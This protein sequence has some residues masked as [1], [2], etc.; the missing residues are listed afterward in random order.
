[1]NID[2]FVVD[3]KE[4]TISWSL[5]GTPVSVNCPNLE[6]ARLF[7][8]SDIVLAISGENGLC[9]TL[10]GFSVEGM[11]KF[12]VAAPEGFL[13]SYLIEHVT[14][15]IA[16]VCAGE[17]YIEGWY[18]WHFAVDPSSGKLSRHCPAY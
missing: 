15:G 8:K 14:A 13:F 9:T 7:P 17:K 16:V 5:N 6:G 2:R 4:S 3:T 1:M 18:D 12:E 10:V 11:R